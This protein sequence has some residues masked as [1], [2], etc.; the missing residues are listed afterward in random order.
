MAN[1]AQEVVRAHGLL[2]GCAGITRLV[3]QARDDAHDGFHGH[4]VRAIKHT[5]ETRSGKREL[6]VYNDWRDAVLM[7]R[8]EEM[9]VAFVADNP[10]K[11]MLHCHL[12]E[13]QAGGMMTWF[14]V[15][16]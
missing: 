14:E 3:R 13:H 11:W 8:T 4:H 10:G 1:V 6:K 2:R 9:E 16:A 7:E 12:V 15:T 5:R